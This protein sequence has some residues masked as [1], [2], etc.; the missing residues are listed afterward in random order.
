MLMKDGLRSYGVWSVSE[1]ASKEVLLT[2]KII[3]DFQ[4]TQIN[5]LPSDLELWFRS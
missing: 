3:I 1:Q 2:R 5:T 4:Q